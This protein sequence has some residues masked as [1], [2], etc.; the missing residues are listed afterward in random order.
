MHCDRDT[1]AD[2]VG[3]AIRC[4][5][6]DALVGTAKVARA[7]DLNAR[8]VVNPNVS[9]LATDVAQRDIENGV[10]DDR[11]AEVIVEVVPTDML[12]KPDG[13][14]S[15]RPYEASV[16]DPITSGVVGIGR[17]RRDSEIER[18]RLGRMAEDPQIVLA[19]A[20]SR[21]QLTVLQDTPADRTRVRRGR[22][23]RVARPADRHH[24]RVRQT[25]MVVDPTDRG[26]YRATGVN[27]GVKSAHTFRGGS[28]R[29]WPVVGAGTQ[30]RSPSL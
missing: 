13:R 26:I 7:S 14:I 3:A 29:V 2:I 12:A 28:T 15:W 21:A 27:R 19:R 5:D 9:V 22:Q 4:V 17:L 16:L 20:Q 30:V 23:H 18:Q 6:S 11:D 25:E 10:A 8:S 24:A 1:D